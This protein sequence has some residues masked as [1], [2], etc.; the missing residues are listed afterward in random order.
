MQSDPNKAIQNPITI[1]INNLNIVMLNMGHWEES[2]LM[3]LDD[4]VMAYLTGRKSSSNN[5]S[6]GVGVGGN[7]GI[8]DCGT[9]MDPF[10]VEGLA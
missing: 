1:I 2:L 6:I 3:R 5:I 4:S 8:S 9:K 7:G 10:S